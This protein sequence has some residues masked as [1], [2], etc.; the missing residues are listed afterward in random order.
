MP[1]W[2]WY[3]NA[4]ST[5]L[6]SCILETYSMLMKDLNSCW[7]A[8]GNL[9]VFPLELQNFSEQNNVIR[10]VYLQSELDVK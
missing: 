8:D 1:F 7:N 2:K 10:E 6:E 9:L 5:L 3:L 4:W